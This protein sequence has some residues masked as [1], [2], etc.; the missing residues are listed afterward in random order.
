MNFGTPKEKVTYE[1]S[2]MKLVSQIYF[3]I[4]INQH[5][6]KN[7][8]V[9]MQN[10]SEL[11]AKKINLRANSEYELCGNYNYKEALEQYTKMITSKI[12]NNNLDYKNLD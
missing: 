4:A 10:E 5:Y 1:R 6:S 8:I 12:R 2:K 9:G 3:K 11:E 7:I